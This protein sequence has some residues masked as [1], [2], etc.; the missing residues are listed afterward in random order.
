MAPSAA[1]AQDIA[2]RL[3]GASIGIDQVEAGEPLYLEN[4]A[5][6]HGEDLVSTDSN[7]K[8][9]SGLSFR[10]NFAVGPL[11]E[12]YHTLRTEMPPGGGSLSNA[13]YAA[14][15]AYILNYN[16]LEPTEDGLLPDHEDDMEG[17]AVVAEE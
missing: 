10:Y 17:V 8:N 15:T 12:V 2:Y 5:A 13:E 4:C 6:C 9:L 11:A 16:G 1:L 3:D 7:A 14:I